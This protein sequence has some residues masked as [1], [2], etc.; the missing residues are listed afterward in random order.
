[1]LVKNKDS[2]TIM[3]VKEIRQYKEYVSVT[4]VDEASNETYVSGGDILQDDFI[5]V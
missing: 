1:V 4:L 3:E 5:L 2:A